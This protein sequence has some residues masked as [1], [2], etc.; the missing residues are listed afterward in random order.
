MDHHRVDECRT[1][2]KEI[3]IHSVSF[4]ADD[5]FVALKDNGRSSALWIWDVKRSR[6]ASQL[7]FASL[8]V[9]FAWHPERC[10]LAVVTSNQTLYLWEKGSI[11]WA[12]LPNRWGGR[13]V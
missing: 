9:A 4:S 10:L 13:E 6:V 7:Q 8:V 1:S 3:G 12:L 2:A 5:R 11:V